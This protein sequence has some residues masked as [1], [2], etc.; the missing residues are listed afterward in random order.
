MESGIRR[1]EW[2][3]VKRKVLTFSVVEGGDY[4]GV[5]VVGGDKG[6]DYLSTCYNSSTHTASANGPATGC[7]G[8]QNKDR[9]SHPS[10]QILCQS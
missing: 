7:F 8:S 2:G 10:M 6:R 9:V 3:N 1:D 4:G 5:V